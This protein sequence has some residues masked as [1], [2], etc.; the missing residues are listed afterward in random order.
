MRDWYQR[1]AGKWIFSGIARRAKL[2]AMTD[3]ER[4]LRF[5][6]DFELAFWSDRWER[7]DA[8][9][10]EDAFRVA[11]CAG[12]LGADDRGRATVLA[13]PETRPDGVWMR[14][15]LQLRRD[16][17]PELAIEGEH[18]ARFAGG[19]LASIEEWL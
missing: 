9:V 4:F 14:Y 2:R 16:G 15:A 1:S 12:S 13:G 19:R 8:H 7:L 18:L 17:L 10:C 5:A 11:H 3:L 6:L